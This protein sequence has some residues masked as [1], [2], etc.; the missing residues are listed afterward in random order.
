MKKLLIQLLTVAA[1]LACAGAGVGAFI[2]A[3]PLWLAEAVIVIAFP[4][5]TVCTMLWWSSGEGT[6]DIPF[7]GY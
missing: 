2:Q 4:V 1:F 3:M 5:F 6:A 7:I